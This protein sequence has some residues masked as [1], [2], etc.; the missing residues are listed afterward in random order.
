MS[1]AESDFAIEGKVREF[2]DKYFYTKLISDEKISGFKR[3]NNTSKDKLKINGEEISELR[4]SQG[5][6]IIIN[7]DGSDLLIDEKC[8]VYYI[9]ES[10]GTFSFELLSKGKKGQ[11]NIGWFIREDL[12]TEYYF[13]LWPYIDQDLYDKYITK[14][15]TDKKQ[16]SKLLNF[17]S[18]EDF[19]KFEGILIK[20]SDI[21]TALKSMDL[22]INK[23]YEKACQIRNSNQTGSI[24]FKKGKYNFYYFSASKSNEYTEQPINLL[25]KRFKLEELATSKYIITKSGYEMVD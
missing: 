15:S 8:C 1:R 6:D 7:T 9:N 19:T 21:L 25:I 23:M 10:I 12:M 16:K 17:I 20:K 18:S 5:V 11:E 3:I 22:D 4:L 13:L 14:N 2:L 24:D